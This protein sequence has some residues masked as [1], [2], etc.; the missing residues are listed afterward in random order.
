MRVFSCH[1]PGEGKMWQSTI[2]TK[3]FA[4]RLKNTGDFWDVG[5]F[6]RCRLQIPPMFGSVIL[7]NLPTRVSVRLLKVVPG[8][9]LTRGYGFG[10]VSDMYPSQF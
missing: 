1:F 7:L 4:D 8:G 5:N 6:Y 2:L 9:I 10:Y 3:I